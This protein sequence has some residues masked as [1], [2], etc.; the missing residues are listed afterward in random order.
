MLFDLTGAQHGLERLDS[1]HYRERSVDFFQK[2]TKVFE[3]DTNNANAALAAFWRLPAV[4]FVP[5]HTRIQTLMDDAHAAFEV[6]ETQEQNQRIGNEVQKQTAL[7]L[8]ETKNI[9]KHVC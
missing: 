8:R 5:T 6:F 3:N 9:R 7:Q 2:L 1:N 4:H